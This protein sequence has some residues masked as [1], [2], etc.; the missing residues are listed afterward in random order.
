VLTELVFDII[1]YVS[2]IMQAEDAFDSWNGL[3]SL[4]KRDMLPMFSSLLATSS[5]VLVLHG[6]KSVSMGPLNETVFVN[7]WCF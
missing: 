4:P 6:D 7:E 2:E 1:D 3:V 5:C